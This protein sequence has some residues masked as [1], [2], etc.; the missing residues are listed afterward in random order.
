MAATSASKVSAPVAAPVSAPVTAQPPKVE[1]AKV[2]E[3]EIKQA[4]PEVKP[5][6]T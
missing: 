3:P 2:P 4:A 6:E 5:V 1:E